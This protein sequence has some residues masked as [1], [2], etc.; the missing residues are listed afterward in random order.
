MGRKAMKYLIIFEDGM[1]YKTDEVTEA[2]ISASNDG[3][4]QII[5]CENMKAHEGPGKDTWSE[6]DE[7][8][9]G[10]G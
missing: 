5:D 6:L 4:L 8:A 2:D 9:Y 10:D 7:W 1:P 3:I